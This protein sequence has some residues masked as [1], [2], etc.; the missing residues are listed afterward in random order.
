[1]WFIPAGHSCVSIPVN[2]GLY[3]AEHFITM[4]WSSVGGKCSYHQVGVEESP[5]HGGSE[6]PNSPPSMVPPAVPCPGAPLPPLWYRCVETTTHFFKNQSDFSLHFS[7]CRTCLSLTHCYI[8]G[9]SQCWCGF[10][11]DTVIF[12]FLIVNIS[13]FTFFPHQSRRPEITQMKRSQLCGAW[14]T[15]SLDFMTQEVSLCTM[16]PICWIYFFFFSSLI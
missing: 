7:F 3:E 2:L 12:Y 1:M 15:H 16:L 8:C 13:C 10:V 6:A 9:C 4:G 11:Y 5:A 14:D